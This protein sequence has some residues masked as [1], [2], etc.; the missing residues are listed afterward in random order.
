MPTS[1]YLKSY[2]NET[3][4]GSL[5]HSAAELRRE[6][7]HSIANR[8]CLD[9]GHTLH[10]QLHGSHDFNKERLKSRRPFVSATRKLLGSL[11]EMGIC[12]L[13]WTKAKL[14]TECSKSISAIHAF[15]PRV[16]TRLMGVGLPRA[17]W[18][19][20]HCLRSGVGRFC[21]S[22]HN[23]ISLHFRIVSVVPLNRLLTTSAHSV[24]HIGHSKEYL[25]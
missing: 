2:S 23:K 25:V 16:S 20:L 24:P 15:I 9:P 18:I 10:G 11:S 1:Y 5:R 3:P 19:K 22:M 13:Q 12:V 17:L 4:S 21:S 14:K 6:G 7:A 8:G